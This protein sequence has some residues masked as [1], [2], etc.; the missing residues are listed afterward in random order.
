[1]I[2]TIGKVT[3]DTSAYEEMETDLF[4]VADRNIMHIARDLSKV[5]YAAK[6]EELSSYQVLYQ[7][8]PLRE[9][10][11]DF[12]PIHKNH[13]VLEIGSGCGAVTGALSRKA[14]SVTCVEA[15]KEKSLVNAHRHSDCDNIVIHVGDWN[16]IEKNLEADYDFICLIDVF[17]EYELCESF[18]N[19]LQKHLTTGGHIVMVLPNKYGMKFFAG[20]RNAAS[21]DYFASIETPRR[22][23]SRN[24]LLKLFAKCGVQ[25]AAF[26]YPYPDYRFATAIYSDVYKP[27][28]GELSNNRQNF[29]GDRMV[30]FDE[31]AAFDGVIED[32]LFNVFANSFVAVIGGGFDVKFAK[33]SN[34]RAPQY[35]IKTTIVKETSGEVY[36]CK[37][38]ITQEATEHVRGMQTAYEGLLARYEG[39][40][41]SINRCELVEE[42]GEV[43]AKFDFVQGTPLS[44][45]MDDCIAKQD[46]EG[47]HKLFDEYLERVGYN[48][49]YPVSDFDL[50]FANVL[51]NGDEWTL[52]DYEWTF[53]KAVPMK[54]LAFRAIYCYL[55]EDEKRNCIDLERVL[56]RLEITQK[57]AE[58]YREQEMDFQKFVTGKRKAMGE[59]RDMIGGEIYEPRKW[60]HKI[61]L[62]ADVSRVQIYED[63]GAGFSE[64]TSYFIED[65]FVSEQLAEFTIGVNGNIKNLRIDPYMDACVVKIVEMAFNGLEVPL[66]NRKIWETNGKVMKGT[67]ADTGRYQPSIVFATQDPNI[68]IDVTALNPAGEN[69]LTVR[70]EVVRLPMA[71]AQDMSGAVKKIF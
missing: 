41:L 44:E 60:L 2:E 54:E 36:V 71:M 53:G 27:G 10:V 38:P 18:V 5:E 28:K 14:A 1:M 31:K 39:G 47:F 70:M 16:Q 32:G 19:T 49:E 29:E 61:K 62:S 35:Q 12:L 30:L 26:Y 8:S 40:N 13:R 23:F 42:D 55:L 48:E 59:L 21:E 56:D 37:H 15:S 17:E 7:Y 58:N 22:G 50:I 9:N 69:V 46:S 25:D 45:L 65:A 33:Y 24:G 43:Y 6:I 34:D 63:M 4:A 57:D 11:V 52:I 20:A 3:I 51:V 64:E 68:S 66:S 67:D